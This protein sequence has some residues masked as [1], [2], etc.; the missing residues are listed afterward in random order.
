[1][2]L[3]DVAGIVGGTAYGNVEFRIASI[4]PPEDAQTLDL[5]FLFES[6]QQT[7]AG[8]II[9]DREIAGKNGIVVEDTKEAMFCLLREL[10]RRQKTAGRCLMLDTRIL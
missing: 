2:K 8:A 6:K 7:K 9:S 4:L 3:N 5:T 1:M 10:G